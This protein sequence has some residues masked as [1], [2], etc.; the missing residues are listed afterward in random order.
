[1]CA[2]F[3]SSPPQSLTAITWLALHCIYKPC[4]DRSKEHRNNFVCTPIPA[5]PLLPAALVN[6]KGCRKPHGTKQN[7]VG[8][9]GLES[10]RETVLSVE[11]NMQKVRNMPAEASR[12]LACKCRCALPRFLLVCTVVSI[13]AMQEKQLGSCQ[14]LSCTVQ[15]GNPIYKYH[16]QG[17]ASAR[18]NVQQA[19]VWPGAFPQPL[20]RAPSW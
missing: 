15:R 3:R 12:Q 16:K 17:I 6:E 19:W 11:G 13:A 20:V 5:M 1:M 9:K 8:T 7:V 4:H 10:I 2:N 14:H 18:C